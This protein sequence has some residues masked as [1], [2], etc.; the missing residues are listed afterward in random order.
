MLYEEVLNREALRM[1]L[2]KSYDSESV[3]GRYAM[4]LKIVS[5]VIQN[6]LTQRQ[7]EV[8]QKYY[9]S[10]MSLDEIA[11]KLQVNKS[12]VSRHLSR[13]RSKIR[14]VLVCLEN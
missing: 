8:S 9:G 2:S 5:G 7:R 14:K 10:G 4:A 12:T 11:Q 13:T 6:C 1:Y 3:D